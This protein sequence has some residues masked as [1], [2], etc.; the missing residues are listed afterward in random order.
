[1]F[2]TDALVA[3]LDSIRSHGKFI[4]IVRWCI[5]NFPFAWRQQTV[6]DRMEET[7][8]SP[9]ETDKRKMATF[10]WII[11]KKLKAILCANSTRA[12]NETGQQ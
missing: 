11:R 9:T 12:R 2:E 6:V 3:V 4:G 5:E 7:K 1:M 8:K 10:K